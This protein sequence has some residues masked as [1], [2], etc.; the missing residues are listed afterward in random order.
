MPPESTHQEELVGFHRLFM[1][2]GRQKQPLGI[3]GNGL[4][5][6]AEPQ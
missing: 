2:S 4:A 6:L 5:C 3:K 1:P